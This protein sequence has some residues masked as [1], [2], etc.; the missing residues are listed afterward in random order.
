MKNKK[1]DKYILKDFVLTEKHIYARNKLTQIY[2]NILKKIKKNQFGGMNEE[3]NNNNESDTNKQIDAAQ[4]ELTVIID[5]DNNYDNVDVDVDKKLTNILNNFS[6]SIKENFSSIFNNNN[7]NIN[8]QLEYDVNELLDVDKDLTKKFI[9]FIND[10]KGKKNDNY[11]KEY[12][13]KIYKGLFKLQ[14]KIIFNKL[15]ILKK[16]IDI[17]PILQILDKK[18]DTMNNYMDTLNEVYNN[19]NNNDET[20]VNDHHTEQNEA[21]NTESITDN[22]TNNNESVPESTSDNTTN[23]NIVSASESNTNNNA[24]D[25]ESN[26]T[27]NY[28]YQNTI[29]TNIMNNYKEKNKTEFLN[30]IKNNYSLNFILTDNVVKIYY[31]LISK[32]NNLMGTYF[33]TL[34][35]AFFKSADKE[36]KCTQAKFLLYNILE[37][38]IYYANEINI[39]NK[40]NNNNNANMINDDTFNS[41]NVPNTTWTPFYNI[42][43]FYNNNVFMANNVCVKDDTEKYT[44]ITIVGILK[45][46]ALDGIKDGFA[47]GNFKID[48]LTNHDLTTNHND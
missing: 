15:N 44:E 13:I 17:A 36:K 14:T 19:A 1:Y 30:K 43:T 11:I 48:N 40:I 41:L 9:D 8:S 10:I 37:L 47:I 3:Q 4:K 31:N 38:I 22:V 12:L 21:S 7:N 39:N 2:N 23:V 6:D 26:T 35:D 5:D 45:S 33:F 25:T 20:K 28:D 27:L 29:A 24:S 46:S 34:T 42:I 16:D 18:L 32:S